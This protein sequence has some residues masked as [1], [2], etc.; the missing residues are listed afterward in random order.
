MAISYHI[1]TGVFGGL[2]PLIVTWLASIM[3]A[4]SAATLWA[5]LA[6]ELGLLSLS[7]LSETRDPIVEVIS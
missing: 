4:S 7:K 6:G 2:T 1:A 3:S 5:V